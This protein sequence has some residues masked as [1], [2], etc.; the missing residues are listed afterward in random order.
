MD[1]IVIIHIEVFG[2]FI[3]LRREGMDFLAGGWLV[4]CVL[5]ISAT[6]FFVFECHKII[7]SLRG[8]AN[9]QSVL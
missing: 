8:E 4:V 7:S 9:V 5:S 1:I 3:I 2:E 6:E